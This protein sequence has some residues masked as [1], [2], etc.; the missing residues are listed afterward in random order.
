MKSSDEMIK[1]LF[2]RRE[3]Y[4][5]EQKRKRRRFLSA[6]SVCLGLCLCFAAF[7]G[8]RLGMR[9]RSG[10]WQAEL[11]GESG[12]DARRIIASFEKGG[13]FD[14]VLEYPTPKNGKYRLSMPLAAAMQHYGNDAVY[15]VFVDFFCDENLLSP[16]Q[17][18]VKNE[19]ERL[20]GLGYEIARKAYF[21]GVLYHEY[22]VMDAK[23]E[24][25]KAFKANE[26]FGYF[27]FLLEE[28]V[29]TEE[30]RIGGAK[31]SCFDS[32]FRNGDFP[33][34]SFA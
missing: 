9:Q 17:E 24:Q 2:A 14:A 18:Q 22:V 23:W 20:T 10:Q 3:L 12:A 8:A 31:T 30:N 21:D 13:S 4:R 33:P 11:P 5:A 27:L 32:A 1:S 6:A 7:G 34:N 29:T 26:A 16:E 25:L 28:R 19:V 15:R